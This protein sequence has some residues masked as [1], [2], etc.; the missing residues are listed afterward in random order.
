MQFLS[1]LYTIEGDKRV[2]FMTV[3][4]NLLLLAQILTWTF[5]DNYLQMENLILVG[6]Y[7][8]VITDVTL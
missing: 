2:W 1:S 6:K 4:V 3:P 8:A 5:N 7:L